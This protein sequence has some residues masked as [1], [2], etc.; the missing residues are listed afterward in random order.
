MLSVFLLFAL[1]PTHIISPGARVEHTHSLFTCSQNQNLK[2]DD[3]DDDDRSDV[4]VTNRAASASF[5]FPLF[6]QQILLCKLGPLS[7]LRQH[8]LEL[9]PENVQHLLPL[10]TS[11]LKFTDGAS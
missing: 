5:F 3:D 6:L 10:I 9:H 4:N 8:P 7:V 1:C 11:F 2:D